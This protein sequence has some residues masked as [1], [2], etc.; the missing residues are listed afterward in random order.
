MASPEPTPSPVIHLRAL[1]KRYPQAWRMLDDFRARRGRDGLPEWPAWCHVPLAGAYAAISAQ[2]GVE[3]I[4][5]AAAGDVGCLGALAAWRVSQGIYRIDPAL[6][7]AL[8]DTP[9]SGDLPCDVLYHLPEWCVYVETPDLAW[10]GTPVY[11]VFA[12]LEWDANDGR[13][14]LRLVLDHGHDLRALP[15]HLGRWSL[16]EAI[17]RTLAEAER[18]AELQGGRMPRAAG[19]A[20]AGA[21]QIEPI[22]SLLLYLC[23]TAAEI[24]ADGRRPSYPAPKG[25]KRGPRYFPPDRPVTWEVGSRIGAALRAAYQREQVGQ[26]GAPTGRRVRPHVRRAHW[27]TYVLGPRDDPAAQRRELRWVPPLP[28]NVDDADGLPAVIRAV[29]PDTRSPG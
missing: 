3:R 18:Q 6:Y 9:V 11:G 4:P 13:A 14:E 20:S 7:T 8:I 15:V 1:G 2:L 21:Q 12:H 25:T 5:H 29:R 28:I 16:S 26:T 10:F 23:S 27:H 22:I 17:A 19:D 24:G